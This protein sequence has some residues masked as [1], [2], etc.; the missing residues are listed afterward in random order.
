MS[1]KIVFIQLPMTACVGLLIVTKR[2]PFHSAVRLCNPSSMTVLNKNTGQT[3]RLSCLSN[4]Q[5][6][7]LYE[8]VS[9]LEPKFVDQDHM[10]ADVS[11]VGR[12]VFQ[13][14]EVVPGAIRC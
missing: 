9:I 3:L 13:Q 10:V 12:W 7:C 14:R 6:D 5:P 2:R 4:F 1:L 11:I 8:A